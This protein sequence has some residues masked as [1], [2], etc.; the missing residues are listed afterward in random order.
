MLLGDSIPHRNAIGVLVDQLT[1]LGWNVSPRD[2]LRGTAASNNR[3]LILMRMLR[4]KLTRYELEKMF[5]G[6]RHNK[7]KPRKE[8]ENGEE[9]V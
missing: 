6:I 8:I 7:R 3:N 1:Q 2:F 5:F 9:N 4:D